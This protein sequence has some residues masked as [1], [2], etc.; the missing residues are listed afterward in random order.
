MRYLINGREVNIYEWEESDENGLCVSFNVKGAPILRGYWQNK[1]QHGLMEM[2]N[3]C[4]VSLF[5]RIYVNGKERKDLL[6]PSM[7]LARVAIFG[8]EIL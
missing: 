4:G 8:R 3:D 5:K 6:D 2:W 1:K 7:R